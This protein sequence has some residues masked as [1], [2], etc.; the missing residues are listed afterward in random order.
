MFFQTL[1]SALGMIITESKFCAGDWVRS[2]R[3]RELIFFNT[4][5]VLVILDL[6]MKKQDFTEF[7]TRFLTHLL[8]KIWTL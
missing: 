8:K 5:Q 6:R 7:M 1:R 4:F 3:M 2:W